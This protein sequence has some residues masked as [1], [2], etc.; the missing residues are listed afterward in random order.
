MNP[1][2]PAHSDRPAGQAEQDA[3]VL[4]AARREKLKRWRDELGINPYG[5]RVK[6]SHRC[7]FCK[8][9]DLTEL[10]FKS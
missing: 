6:C 8:C 2:S 4:I 1:S 7:E 5:Q 3:S 9:P 10:G